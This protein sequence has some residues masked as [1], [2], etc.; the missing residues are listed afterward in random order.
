V[1]FRPIDQA[2]RFSGYT[3]VEPNGPGNNQRRFDGE[4]NHY[5]QTLFFEGDFSELFPFLDKQ[6]SRG[7]DFGLAIGRQ[8]IRFQDG[9]LIDDNLDAFGITKINLKPVGMVNCR[10]TLLWS[11]NELNRQNLTVQDGSASPIGL[12]NEMDWRRST[13]E[14]DMIYVRADDLSGDGLY[15]G[16]GA[17]QRIG[18]Y[19]TTFRVLGSLPIGRKTVHNSAGL[20]LFST[21][22]WTPRGKHNYFYANSFL[23]IDR[24]RSASRGP[25]SGGPLNRTGILFESVGL[26]G[27]GVD[28]GNR[29]DD[30]FGGAMGYQ[31]FFN[32]TRS[33]LL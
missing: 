32:H 24:F 21:V 27:Y 3:F 16:F 9:M 12:F 8:R 1:G 4:L 6:D 17:T 28:L 7:L 20:L 33:Q 31:M 18:G 19:N 5:L 14:M 11:W 29:S 2:G 30:T 26:G 13:I 23:G 22:S 15:T 25:M 10:T